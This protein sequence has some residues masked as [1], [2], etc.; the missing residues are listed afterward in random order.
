MELQMDKDIKSNEYVAGYFSKQDREYIEEIIR[1]ELMERDI[2]D[3][4]SFNWKLSYT[5]YR[6]KKEN[7]NG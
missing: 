5:V 1:E 7:A 4:V 3:A 6:D 2:L